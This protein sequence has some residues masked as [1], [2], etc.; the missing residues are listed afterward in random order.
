[1]R[2]DCQCNFDNIQNPCDYCYARGLNC[3]PKLP[4][5]RKQR[6]QGYYLD[7]SG[8]Q[9]RMI[10]AAGTLSEQFPGHL[11]VHIPVTFSQHNQPEFNLSSH[12]QDRNCALTSPTDGFKPYSATAGLANL[13]QPVSLGISI[14][15]SDRQLMPPCWQQASPSAQSTSPEPS[16]SM[17]SPSEITRASS[18]EP[19]SPP[20]RHPAHTLTHAFLP[21]IRTAIPQAQAEEVPNGDFPP[22]MSQQWQRE[23]EEWLQLDGPPPPN[24]R[25]NWQKFNRLLHIPRSMI[26]RKFAGKW[27]EDAQSMKSRIE[28]LDGRKSL[29]SV[30]TAPSI[31]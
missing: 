25:L 14:P 3:G 30:Q 20:P 2:T 12:C 11:Q 15:S 10:T 6:E 29:Q 7:D 18:M 22:E 28:E 17:Y 27:E 19:P 23:W 1:M 4:T 24:A 21:I 31:L 26:G 9:Y 13:M 8:T 16:S 5:P